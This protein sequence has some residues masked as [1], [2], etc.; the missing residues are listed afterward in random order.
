MRQFILGKCFVVAKQ[1]NIFYCL[2]NQNLWVYVHQVLHEN[3]NIALVI[4]SQECDVAKY[5]FISDLFIKFYL[6]KKNPVDLVKLHL[7]FKSGGVQLV[8]DKKPTNSKGKNKNNKSHTT[9]N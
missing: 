1:S 2:R 6:F 4:V 8:Y 9:K 3:N 5:K 7:K